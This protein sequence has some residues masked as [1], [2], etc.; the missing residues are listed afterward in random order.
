[1][2]HLSLLH[3]S[4]LTACVTVFSDLRVGD[5]GNSVQR[6]DSIRQVEEGAVAPEGCWTTQGGAPARTGV[7]RSIP[8]LADPVEA[9]QHGPA[10]FEG[11]PVVWGKLVL[12]AAR[13]SSTRR[14]L[15]AFELGTGRL[16]FHRRFTASVPLE[17]SIW[18]DLIAVR[19]SEERAELFRIRGSRLFPARTFQNAKGV[20]APLLFQDEIYVRE[21][22][23]LVAYHP[24]RRE[25]RWRAKIEGGFRGTPSL[26]GAFVYGGWYD[27]AGNLHIASY[28]R[29]EGRC[30]SDH[31]AG[32]HD[33]RTIPYAAPL[34]L[35]IHE[36]NIFVEYP[37]PARSTNNQG[38]AWGRL[39]R[40]GSGSTAL[41]PFATAPTPWEQGWLVKEVL[42]KR[43]NRWIAARDD[44]EGLRARVLSDSQHQPWLSKSALPP[45]RT[46]DV[47]YF[48]PSAVSLTDFSIR[49]RRSVQLLERPVPAGG[50]LLW[51]EKD[52][53]RAMRSGT[54]PPDGAEQQANE[55]VDSLRERLARDL[56]KLADKALH[57]GDLERALRLL[58][59]AQ[60]GGAADRQ[61]ERTRAKLDL[62]LGASRPPP[63]NRSLIRSIAREE[64]VVRSRP[65]ARLLELA[66]STDDGALERELL[67]R[68][69]AGDPEHEGATRAVGDLIPQGFVRSR[70]PKALSWLE[71]L[72]VH[73]RN[74]VRY[75]E[76]PHSTENLAPEQEALLLERERWRKDIGGY[77]SDRLLVITPPGRPG[78]VARSLEV[79]ELVCDLLEG[80]FGSAGNAARGRAPLTL[81]MYE[82]RDEYIRNSR[83][84]KSGPEIAL[85]WT[86]GHYSPAENLSRMYVPEGDAEYAEL[87]GVYAHE[88][89]HHWLRARSPMSFETEQ[90]ERSFDQPGYWIGEGFAT[91]IEEFL[92]D[93]RRA[94]WNSENA[95]A[96]S[97]DTVANATPDQLLSWNHIL[98]ASYEDFIELDSHG[99]RTIPITWKLG[100]HAQRSQIQ[101]FYA[102]SGA[103]CNYLYNGDGG[104]H[105][106]AL[107]N[108]VGAWYRSDRSRL[109]A[110]RSFGMSAKVLGKRTREY[111]RETIE[112]ATAR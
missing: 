47:A 14:T 46:G 50:H 36:N 75:I 90:T 20:S 85:G 57:A 63:V 96:S 78:A 26:R 108:Y 94:T 10:N 23:D 105:R 12:A 31:V 5:H 88:L 71:F 35:S 9:W 107:I 4:A 112:R 84:E 103:L 104:R 33:R 70:S 69:L 101:M 92:L 15:Y 42:G 6:R 11:E 17:L 86:A 80:L 44:E 58:L 77:R 25:P 74:P 81:L 95:Y 7:S 32:H 83:R 41:H 48:G 24:Q 2:R 66:S 3:I 34:T 99:D 67:R 102:Q 60:D 62:A 39:A 51:V 110:K 38:L 37:Y 53:L 65:T 27:D 56:G 106:R 93:P 91:L 54:P 73:D 30:R 21:G 79:G 43:N 82:T 59:E 1:M 68:I 98:N 109:D 55:R 40:Q 72:D 52:R 28:D 45:S 89:T 100:M 19:L 97:L 16:L 64:N 18:E 49:W 111:A 87:L 61:L 8:V 29:R 13:D 22:D 76:A